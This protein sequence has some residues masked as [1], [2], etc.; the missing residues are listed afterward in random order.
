MS[1]FNIRQEDIDLSLQILCPCCKNVL[2]EPVTL[3]CKRNICKEHIKEKI[4][5]KNNKKYF[6]CSCCLIEHPTDNQGSFPLNE[7]I[8]ELIKKCQV[9]ATPIKEIHKTANESYD[10]LI[11]KNNFPS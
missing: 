6:Q 7:K 11:G 10:K 2:I 5:N 1:K 9:R 4:I 8:N 3:P